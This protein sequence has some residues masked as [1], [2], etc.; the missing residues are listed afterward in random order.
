MPN[1]AQKPDKYAVSGATCFY[2]NVDKLIQLLPYL[3]TPY[4]I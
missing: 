2:V 4:I 3:A 1:T